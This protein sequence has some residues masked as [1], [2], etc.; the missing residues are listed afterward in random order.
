MIFSSVFLL[1]ALLATV[2]A[3]PILMVE[4]GHASHQVNA[5]TLYQFQDGTRLENIAVRR[6]GNLLV[7]LSDRPELYEVNPF[8]PAP[9]KLI[10][11]FAGYSGLGGITKIT[12]DVF[13]VN[14]RN[15]TFEPI[16]AIPKSFAVW[17]VDLN[18]GSRAKVSKVADMPDALFLNGMTTL[19]S[20]AGTILVGDCAGG[21]VFR[22]DTQTG[23]YTVA[24]DDKLL[25]PPPDAILPVG[26]NGIRLTGNYLYFTN[27]FKAQSGIPCRQPR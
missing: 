1:P 14:A 15:T 4:R 6:N 25:Q 21:R 24:L 23:D 19:D 11:H 7:T 17:K 22:V 26:V 20:R 8:N 12:P 16:T 9:P 3:W 27:S 10:H 13:T 2:K 18:C 5:H